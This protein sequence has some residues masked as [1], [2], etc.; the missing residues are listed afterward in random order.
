MLRAAVNRRGSSVDDASPSLSG[1]LVRLLSANTSLL[2]MSAMGKSNEAVAARCG[3]RR[4]PGLWES[5]ASG[6]WLTSTP[7]R[8]LDI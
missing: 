8:P 2:Q 1:G 3:D 4:P 7:T 5:T 6:H